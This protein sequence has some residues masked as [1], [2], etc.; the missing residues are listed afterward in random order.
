MK[1]VN[2]VVEIGIASAE[3]SCEPVST[4]LDNSFAIGQHF[5]LSGLAGSNHGIYAE[6]LLDEGRETRNLGFVVESCRA[7][8]YLD[9]HAVLQP[10]FT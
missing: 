3:H 2:H 6:P 7:G 8:T 1:L 5:K 10:K 9:F 4:A